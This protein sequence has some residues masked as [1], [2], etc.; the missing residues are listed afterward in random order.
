MNPRSIVVVSHAFSRAVNRQPYA[1][2]QALGWQVELV[3][4]QALVQDGREVAS[5]AQEAGAP[6]VHF[7]PLDGASSRTY[8]FVG[9]RELL[10]RLR[11]AWVACDNDPHSLMAVRLAAWKPELGYRLAFVSCEN[12]SFGVRASFRRRGLRGLLLGLFCTWT[13]WR[14]RPR[15]DLVWAISDAGV[16]L[17]EQAGFARVR[18]TPLGFPEQHFRVDAIARLR[19]REQMGLGVPALAYFGRL[20]PEKGVHLLLDA[21][22]AL[23]GDWALMIDEFMPEGDYQREL[24]K[25]LESPAWRDR[26]RRVHARHGEVG[27]YMNAADIVALPSI[28]TPRWVEQY[29]RVAPEAMACGCVVVAA[30][31]G[32]LPELVGD[33]GMLFPE[34]DVDALRGVLAQALAQLPSLDAMRERAAERAREHFSSR[35]Q[36]RLWDRELA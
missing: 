6:T 30:R 29:G 23:P 34:G 13:R 14:V 17:F 26:V 32:A 22:E 10:E 20:S 27:D 35:A 19:I 4:A 11:P 1:E 12:L 24:S 5:D 36:A 28:S 31:S 15:T 18:K 33:A 25:R 9:L 21:L 8:A 2:L 3:T 7:L 16:A